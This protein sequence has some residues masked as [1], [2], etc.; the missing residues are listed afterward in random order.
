V[1]AG[2]RHP[3]FAGDGTEANPLYLEFP[4]LSGTTVD[5]GRATKLKATAKREAFA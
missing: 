2:R 3:Q 4:D 1:D 5:R